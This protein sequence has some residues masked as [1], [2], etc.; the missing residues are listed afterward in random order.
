MRDEEI[1]CLSGPDEF[2]EFYRRLKNLKDFHRRHPNEIEPPM[3]MEFLRL[4]KQRTQPPEHLQSLADFTDEEGYGKHLDMHHL[5]DTFINLRQ[6]K[7]SVQWPGVRED[8]HSAHRGASV[9]VLCV[10]TASMSPSSSCNHR[11][12]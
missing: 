3:A 10:A 5:Y 6:M 9:Q 4:D 11:G 2:G 8:T 7:V 1:N 12:Y